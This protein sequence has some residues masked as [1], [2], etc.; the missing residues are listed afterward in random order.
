MRQ[1]LRQFVDQALGR[2]INDH[3]DIREAI[4]NQPF[5]LVLRHSRHVHLNE[6]ALY[7][8]VFG[9]QGIFISFIKCKAERA[10]VVCRLLTVLNVDQ[11][12]WRP[13]VLKRVRNSRQLGRRLNLLGRQLLY[14][15]FFFDRLQDSG[16]CIGNWN[17]ILL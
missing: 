7:R 15:N 3:A 2:R 17:P 1:A 11:S 12:M 6:G 5:D 10:L 14:L 13:K 9:D 16:D 4:V 8:F